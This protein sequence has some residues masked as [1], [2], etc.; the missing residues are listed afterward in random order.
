MKTTTYICDKCKKSVGEDE[1]VPLS[2]SAYFIQVQNTYKTTTKADRDICKSCLREK[3]L[4][5]EADAETLKER[6]GRNEKTLEDKMLE[7]LEELGVAFLE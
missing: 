5:V 1:L 6:T 2:I 4:L 7:I 3:G